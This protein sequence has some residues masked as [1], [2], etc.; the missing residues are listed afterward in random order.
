MLY[1]SSNIKFNIVK[2]VVKYRFNKKYN[3][4]NVIV[5]IIKYAKS[6]S[7][8]MEHS[9]IWCFSQV[10]I[11]LHILLHKTAW[12]NFSQIWNSSVI[13][14]LVKYLLFRED[15]IEIIIVVIHYAINYFEHFIV[16]KNISLLKKKNNF[17]GKLYIEEKD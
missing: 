1:F 10:D 9:M 11:V 8:M 6:T 7:K 12:Y 13:K 14:K 5:F 16:D 4:T 15:R 17:T 2:H 3:I